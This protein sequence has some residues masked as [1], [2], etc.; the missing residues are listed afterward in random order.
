MGSL[1]LLLRGLGLGL[2]LRLRL[3]RARRTVLGRLRGQG[4]ASER[5]GEHGDSDEPR[6]RSTSLIAYGVH[7]PPP[8]PWAKGPPL[9]PTGD[10]RVHS[11]R[12]AIVS[13]TAPARKCIR[14]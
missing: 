1:L 12:A 2:G 11:R 5:D 10:K 13:S 8:G 4:A 3:V 6:D 7:S 14:N 9:V